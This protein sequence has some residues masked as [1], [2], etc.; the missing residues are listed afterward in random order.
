MHLHLKQ[1]EILVKK[2]LQVSQTHYYIMSD[3]LFSGQIIKYP[4]N[5]LYEYY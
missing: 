2:V 1:K 5:K 4:Y 3:T